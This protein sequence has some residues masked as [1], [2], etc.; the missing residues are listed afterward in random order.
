MVIPILLAGIVEIVYGASPLLFLTA[1]AGFLLVGL[2]P[3]MNAHSQTIWQTQ[4]PR[5]LQGRV[6]SVRRVIAQFSSPI[7]IMM[8]GIAGAE[9]NPGLILV[10]LGSIIV[11]FSTVQLF[12][13]YLLRVEDKQYLDQLAIKNGEKAENLIEPPAEP[14]HHVSPLPTPVTES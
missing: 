4:V 13:P 9:L 11:I 3:F 7:G 1:G 12:N 8:G 2:V 5:H 6:F 10:V 14:I